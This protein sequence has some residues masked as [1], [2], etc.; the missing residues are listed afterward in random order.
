MRSAGWTQAFVENLGLR[1][2]QHHKPL[3]DQ[4]T[5]LNGKPSCVHLLIFEIKLMSS[6][7][8]AVLKLTTS[9]YQAVV[10][11]GSKIAGRTVAA[12]AGF[13]KDNLT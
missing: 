8:E 10:K 4:A 5:S 13:K 9:W 7:H 1:Q 12:L 11:L 2:D 6:P 3:N